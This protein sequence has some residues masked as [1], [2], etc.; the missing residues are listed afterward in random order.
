MSVLVPGF[1]ALN[2]GYA[3]YL[4]STRTSGSIVRMPQR[5][6]AFQRLMTLLHV[7]LANNAIVRE[8]A[9]L[10]DAVTHEQREIDILVTTST[11]GYEFRIGIE[12]V[13]RSRPM[14]TPWVESMHAKRS[15]L[16]IDKLVLVSRSG[17][18]L[19]A[20]RKARFYGIET[21]TVESAL[22]TDWPLLISLERSG[23][24]QMVS[25]RFECNAVCIGEDQTLNRIPAPLEG[26]LKVGEIFLTVGDFARQLLDLPQ[27]QDALFEHVGGCGEQDFWVAYA[28]PKGMWKV[29]RGVVVARISEMWIGLKVTSFQSAVELASGSYRGLPFVSGASLPCRRPPEIE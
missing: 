13:D 21:L 15:N 20:Q 7:T 22:N 9:M 23:V 16:P 24:F 19:P 17:F 18:T 27:F 12:V 8:S 11:A 4:R 2:P 3:C 29:E 28:D 5:T 25:L 10:E 26:P 14:G 6:N 1:A